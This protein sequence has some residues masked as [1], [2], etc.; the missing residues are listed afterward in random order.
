MANSKTNRSSFDFHLTKLEHGNIIPGE[1]WLEYTEKRNSERQN[2][3]ETEE[4]YEKN[5]PKESCSVRDYWKKKKRVLLKDAVT[6]TNTAEVRR[7]IYNAD[8]IDYE[9]RMC[10]KQLAH[11]MESK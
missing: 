3:L 6:G 1:S 10:L 9:K 8:N 2:V 7:S 5:Y 4:A 11:E